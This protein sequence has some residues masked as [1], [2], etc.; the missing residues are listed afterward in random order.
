MSGTRNFPQRIENVGDNLA[1]GV[2]RNC[3]VEQNPITSAASERAR[4]ATP[5]SSSATAWTLSALLPGFG[6]S[7]E[8]EVSHR[9]LTH[10]AFVSCDA[11]SS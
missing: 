3:E 6:R 9:R 2:V 11:K 10:R 1:K 7:F 5:S 8:S 4:I